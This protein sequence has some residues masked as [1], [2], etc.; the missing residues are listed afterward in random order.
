MVAYKVSYYS[1]ALGTAQEAYFA[2]YEDA[3]LWSM[4]YTDSIIDAIVIHF[5]AI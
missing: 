1:P 2:R 4:N 5:K 3:K